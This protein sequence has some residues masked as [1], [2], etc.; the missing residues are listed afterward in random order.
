MMVD[1]TR[2][3]LYI[4]GALVVLA[5]LIGNDDKGPWPDV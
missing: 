4:L 1:P 3:V 5:F 2:A